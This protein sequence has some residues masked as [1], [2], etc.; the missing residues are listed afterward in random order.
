MALVVVGWCVTQFGFNFLVPTLLAVL[1]SMD[2]LA[3]V[4]ER[5]YEAHGPRMGLVALQLQETLPATTIHIFSRADAPLTLP[6][7][8]LLDAF[9]QEAVLLRESAV[10]PIDRPML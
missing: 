3:I 6:A 5:F 7:Q 2:T 8:R 4:P 10:L 1:P 9:L